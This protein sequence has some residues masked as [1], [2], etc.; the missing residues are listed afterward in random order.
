MNCILY[1]KKKRWIAFSWPIAS[2]AL[3][4]LSEMIVHLYVQAISQSGSSSISSQRMLAFKRHGKT[5]IN[6]SSLP[7]KEIWKIWSSGQPCPRS[8]YHAW[9]IHGPWFAS[10]LS[11]PVSTK[12]QE[13][14]PDAGPCICRSASLECQLQRHSRST[15][16]HARR[17]RSIKH[18][19]QGHVTMIMTKL[20]GNSRS[21]VW[22]VCYSWSMN[23]FDRSRDPLIG[24]HIETYRRWSARNVALDPWQNGVPDQENKMQW[25]MHARREKERPSRGHDGRGEPNWG[26]SVCAF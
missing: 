21:C 17:Y 4:Q 7:A 2:S 14:F 12:V 10:A 11:Y 19:M 23:I 15:T 13:P 5:S 16:S 8:L 9:V 6:R 1:F 25:S 3:L 18:I 26:I 22:S 24:T 20:K